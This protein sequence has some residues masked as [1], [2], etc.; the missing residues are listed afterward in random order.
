MRSFRRNSLLTNLA[1]LEQSCT[2]CRVWFEMK[3]CLLFQT[4]VLVIS[5]SSQFMQ[6]VEKG[7]VLMMSLKVSL[8]L[9][10]LMP[11]V[12][13]LSLQLLSR[14]NLLLLLLMGS[15]LSFSNKMQR[16]M[17][18]SLFN[19]RLL[20]ISSDGEIIIYIQHCCFTPKATC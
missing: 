10:L 8:S 9:T 1:L 11:H 2:S 4:I 20:L 14:V 15:T 12:A 17:K 18:A 16:I 5:S 13:L 3:L 19:H 6:C 7:T